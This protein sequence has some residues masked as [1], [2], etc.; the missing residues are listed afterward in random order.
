[1]FEEAI[2]QRTYNT[3]AKIKRSKVQTMIY[4]TLQRKL[5]IEKHEP[6]LKPGVNSGTLE[7]YLL[8]HI[9]LMAR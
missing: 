1:M 5:K 4:K 8:P 6:H 7:G 9:R 3:M 2:N